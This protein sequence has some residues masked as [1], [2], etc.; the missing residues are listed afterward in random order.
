VGRLDPGGTVGGEAAGG[1]EEVDVGVVG[2]GAGPG[3]EHGKNRDAAADPLG[4]GREGLDG[5]GG[6]AK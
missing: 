4:I 6:L 5:S 3:V 2:E 1:D